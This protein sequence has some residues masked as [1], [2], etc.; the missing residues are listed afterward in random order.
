VVTQ[1]AVGK[2]PRQQTKHQQRTEQRQHHRV[3]KPQ[4]TCPLTIDLHR[5]IHPLKGVFTECAIVAELLD[6]QKTSVGLEAD[7]P[8]S[9]KIHQPFVDVE[10]TRIVDGRLRA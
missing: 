10:V 7:L 8:Q 2:T 5:F 4:G 1:F 9:G 6:V 3:A